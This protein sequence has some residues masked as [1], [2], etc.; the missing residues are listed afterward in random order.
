MNY[1]KSAER[2]EMGKGEIRISEWYEFYGNG[3]YRPNEPIL[4]VDLKIDV[5]YIGPMNY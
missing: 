4:C 1:G 2:S 5:N 3:N